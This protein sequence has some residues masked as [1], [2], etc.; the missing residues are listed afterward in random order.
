MELMEIIIL[1]LQIVL[2]ATFL[3]FGLLKMFLPIEKIEK[4]VTWANDYSASKLKFF[5]F[6]H[7]S[8]FPSKH[9]YEAT[10]FLW[11]STVFCSLFGVFLN[12]DNDS[13]QK[14]YFGIDSDEECNMLFRSPVA[15][16][17]LKHTTRILISSDT[18]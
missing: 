1:G 8:H 13:H 2:C 6:F 10:C 9:L 18:V 17:S 16:F 7:Q 14:C 4:K 12:N 11:K 5:G 15:V 3:Y